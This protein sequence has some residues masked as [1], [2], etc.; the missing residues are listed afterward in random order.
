MNTLRR[1]VFLTIAVLS[2]LISSCDD[3]DNK[4]KGEFEHGVFVVNEGN[5]QHADGSI[6][7]INPS[8]GEVSYDLF[9]AVN[10]GRALG[11]VVQ[12]MT[13]DNDQA[14]I[15]VNNSNKIEVVNA[16]TFKASYTI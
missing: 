11:D 3:D 12:S 4:P 7:Y 9:G 8:S 5:F 2:F 16:N 14:Y 13:I 6:S 1:F 15:V 10:S